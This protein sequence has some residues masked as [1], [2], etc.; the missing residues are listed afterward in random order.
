MGGIS[1]E[2][3]PGK[4]GDLYL[5]E[6]AFNDGF[7][8][9]AL[10]HFR[11]YLKTGP[12]KK[13]RIQILISRCQIELGNFTDAL[14]GLQE[15]LELV[16]KSK[17]SSEA[18]YWTAQ[19]YFIAQ[20][21]SNALEFFQKIIEQYPDTVQLASSTYYRASCYY[22]LGKFIEALGFYEEFNKSFPRNPL[23][24]QGMFRLGECLY[25]TKDYPSARKEFK[26]FLKHFPDSKYRDSAFYYLGEIEYIL[27]NF[28][29]AIKR[30]KQAQQLQVKGKIA[31]LATYSCGWAYLRLN[32]H[33]KA[34]DEF[35]DLSQSAQFSKSFEDAIIFAKARAHTDLKSYEQAI[36]MYDKLINDFP[37]SSWFDDAY[38]WKGQA[39]YELKQYPQAA[40][41]YQQALEKFSNIDISREAFQEETV[42]EREDISL[43][44]IDNLNYNLGWTYARM[45]KY[46]EAIEQFNRVLVNS[47]QRFL[48]SRALVRIGDVY[49][50][51]D[52][53]EEAIHNYDIVLKDYPDSYYADYAQY[54]LGLCFFREESFDSAVW[55][56][57]ALIANFSQS[58]LLA[59][60]YYQMGLIYFRQARFRQAQEILDKLINQTPKGSL[61]AAANFLKACAYYNEEEYDKAVSGFNAVLGSSLSDQDLKIRAQY[62]KAHCFYQMGKRAKAEKEFTK[63]LQSYPDASLASDVLFWLGQFYYQ[64]K[65]LLLAEESFAMLLKRFPQDELAGDAIFWQAKLAL[66]NENSERALSKLEYLRQV[67]SNSDIIAEGLLLEGDILMQQSDL[68]GADELYKLALAKS[69]QT[70]FA[71]LAH[72]KIAQI[73]QKNRLYIQAIA[74]YTQA[75]GSQSSDFNARIQFSIAECWYAQGELPQALDSYLKVIYLYPE[76]VVYSQRAQLR[77]A[78]I[79]EQQDNWAKANEIYQKLASEDS[80][81]AQLAREKLKDLKYQ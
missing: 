69:Q 40:T 73:N 76:P 4:R 47:K 17:F 57:S 19:T 42:Y 72:Q 33:R 54:Q 7:H 45:K 23:K 43:T 81:Q 68:E 79:F 48:R 59:E 20:D 25:S 55:A 63:F 22:K 44:I 27:G 30:Y 65:N 56:F 34:L 77:C 5:A 16:P 13:E 10:K 60:A 26:A 46:P 62:Q 74:E 78:E 58:D 49:L 1:S 31:A 18:T 53:T 51:Q 12:D 35:K 8:G 24:E 38:F 39:L 29:K 66:A 15:I 41:V 75:L 70:E 61:R 32:E 14:H 50:E 64:E 21:Y 28:S 71:R 11:E 80:P 2:A 9:I 37:R 3:K 52:N 36:I 67:Y 6:A